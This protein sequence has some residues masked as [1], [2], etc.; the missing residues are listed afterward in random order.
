MSRKSLKSLLISSSEE[1]RARL[2]S[3]GRDSAPQSK[4]WPAENWE[5]LLIRIHSLGERALYAFDAETGKKILIPLEAVVH[6]P[7]TPP[8]E[9]SPGIETVILVKSWAKTGFTSW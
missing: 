1:I 4:P 7:N 9:Q 6:V 3:P 5:P 2:P 8:A